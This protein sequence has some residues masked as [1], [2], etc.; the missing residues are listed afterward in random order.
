[1]LFYL[2]KREIAANPNRKKEIMK[3]ETYVVR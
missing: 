2:S 1:M 3:G